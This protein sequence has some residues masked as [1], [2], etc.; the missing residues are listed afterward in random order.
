MRQEAKTETC[1]YSVASPE[2]VLIH[3]N[4]IALKTAKT[5]ES[6]SRFE[7]NGVKFH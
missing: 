5:L 1:Y 2:R 3:L 6:F 4:P 7:C